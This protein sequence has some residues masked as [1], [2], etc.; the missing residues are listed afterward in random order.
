[1]AML[2]T[3]ATVGPRKNQQMSRRILPRNLNKISFLISTHQELSWHETVPNEEDVREKWAISRIGTR[4]SS[5]PLI[6]LVSIECISQ[7]NHF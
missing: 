3:E 2:A 1:M 5:P 7:R 6:P 4:A